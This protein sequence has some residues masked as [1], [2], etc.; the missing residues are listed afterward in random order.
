MARLAVW[1]GSQS[2]S[3]TFLPI[4]AAARASE[5]PMALLLSSAR[6]RSSPP[7]RRRHRD[8]QLAHQRGHAVGISGWR[9]NPAHVAGPQRD[10]DREFR[11]GSAGRST[12]VRAAPGA[13][14]GRSRRGFGARRAAWLAAAGAA[15]AGNG[16]DRQKAEPFASAAPPACPAANPAE[17]S[18][19]TISAAPGR[20]RARC[21]AEALEM[22]RLSGVSAASWSWVWRRRPTKA[23][24]CARVEAALDCSAC[25]CTRDMFWPSAAAPCR[26]GW[27]PANS[28]APAPP[29]RRW[30]CAPASRFTSWAILGSRSRFCALQR[31]HLGM[32]RAILAGEFAFLADQVGLLGAQAARSGARTPPGR[33]RRCCRCASAPGRGHSAPVFPPGRS[34]PARSGR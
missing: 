2:S 24:Y 20:R 29:S 10:R 16:T 19:S 32:Q 4:L 23:S 3:T 7:R 26:P 8:S 13:G 11:P 17:S 9:D 1:A 34:A 31:L 15:G 5:T 6:P 33:H 27:P 18:A 25:S 22:M 12:P 14:G 21:G 28:D 30:R